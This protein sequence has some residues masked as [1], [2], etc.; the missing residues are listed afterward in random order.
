[1]IYKGKHTVLGVQV[2]AVDYDAAVSKIVD[3]AHDRRPFAVSALAVHGVMTG[4]M[5]KAHRYRLNAFNLICPDGQP[6]RW[7]LRW[8]HGVQLPERVYG[9]N[10]MLEVCRAA[11]AQGLPIFLFGAKASVLEVLSANL[12]RQFP[13]L[14]IV[15]TRASK[16]RQLDDVEWENLV[17]EV[18]SSGAQIMF[19]GLGCPRQEVFTFEVRNLVSMPVIAVGAAFNFHSGLLAQAPSAMQRYGL[20][21][22]FRLLH[23]PKRL[24]RRYLLLN[25]AYLTL[26]GMQKLGVHRIDSASL[27]PP[28]SHVL[29]G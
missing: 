6:V 21:W 1:M 17:A 16:F 9:P 8:L 20:E 22:L 2:D 3:A 4:V 14:K 19:V 12:L 13:K 11:E 26:I 25:P 28:P 18:R 10:L 7:A 24:W 15:G 29:Y 27:K 5:D 23:E